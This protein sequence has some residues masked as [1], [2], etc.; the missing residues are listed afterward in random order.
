[1]LIANWPVAISPA[2]I[3]VVEGDNGE[4]FAW[5]FVD[6]ACSKSCVFGDVRE[7]LTIESIWSRRAI[8]DSGDMLGG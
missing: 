1:M 6:V 8:R 4:M 3:E 7:S 2:L 5:M